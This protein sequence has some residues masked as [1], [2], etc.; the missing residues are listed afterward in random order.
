MALIS[1]IAEH[2]DV[3]EKVRNEQV[4]QAAQ[5]VAGRF[6]VLRIEIG[7]TT[8]DFREII[9]AEL[10]DG[11]A[12][13]GLDYRFPERDQITNHKKAFED[14]MAVFHAAYPE[15]G[16]LLAVDELLDYLKDRKQ[17]QTLQRDLGFLRE[18]GEVCKNLRFRFMAGVQEAIFDTD[19]FA[20][21]APTMKRVKDR[22]EQ[23]LIARKDVRFVVSRRLLQKTPEQKARIAAYLAPFAKFYDQMNERMDEYV[24]LFPIHP[25]YINTFQKIK[26]VEKRDVLRT[27]SRAMKD[28]LAETAP[29]NYPGV[30]AYDGYWKHLRENSAHRSSPDIREVIECSE[31]LESK[32]AQSF[33]RPLYK[34]MALRFRSFKQPL[35]FG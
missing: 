26:A 13:L 3:V 23:V 15:H 34:P 35:P 8:R 18:I 12:K 7:S 17:L 25:E 4:K 11:L 30:I 6:K 22:F 19:T 5:K 31:V 28:I 32:V 24:D 1:A 9:C 33:T 27:F 16:L 14:M 2:A 10:S 21:A 29:G 20:F